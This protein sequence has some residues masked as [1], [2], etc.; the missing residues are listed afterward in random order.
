MGT[1]QPSRSSNKI[2][3]YT[4]ELW[5]ICP[6]R[7]WTFGLANFRIA[8]KHFLLLSVYHWHKQNNKC[9]KILQRNC[10]KCANIQ[11]KVQSIS[12][13]YVRMKF[14][15][16]QGLLTVEQA[17]FL[18]LTHSN[19]TQGEVVALWKKYSKMYNFFKTLH[20]YM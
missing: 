7:N 17:P 18:F 2:N 3:H 5:R 10:L 16:L 15:S 4:V 20:K 9:C 13:L 6:C 12:M 1:V 19:T 8:C 11:N 14:L